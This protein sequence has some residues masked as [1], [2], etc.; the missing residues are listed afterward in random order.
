MIINNT[1]DATYLKCLGFELGQ[2]NGFD[3]IEIKGDDK[4]IQKALDN[5]NSARMKPS[6]LIDEYKYIVYLAKKNSS[7]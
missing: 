4:E 1:T 5:E 7:K 3:S 2:V 6:Y